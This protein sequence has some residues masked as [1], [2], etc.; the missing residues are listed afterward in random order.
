MRQRW[1][2]LSQMCNLLLEDALA[3]NQNIISRSAST[4]PLTALNHLDSE[5][6]CQAVRY[7]SSTGWGLQ[8]VPQLCWIADG[9]WLTASGSGFFVLDS[10]GQYCAVINYGLRLGS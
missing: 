1:A 2:N 10:S 7:V 4:P 3:S 8:G 9:S 5:N 6:V